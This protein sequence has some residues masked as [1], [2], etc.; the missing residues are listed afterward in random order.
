MSIVLGRNEADGSIS[1]APSIVQKED[2]QDWNDDDCGECAACKSSDRSHRALNGRL[3]PYQKGLDAERA[4]VAP[5]VFLAQVG[6]NLATGEVFA[7]YG[8]LPHQPN[9]AAR[10]SRR[11]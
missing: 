9:R 4:S 8:D 5:S 2:R 7:Q 11:K 3:I 10:Q 1:Q 6:G